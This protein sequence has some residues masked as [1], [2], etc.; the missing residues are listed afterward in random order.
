MES[1]GLGW[2]EVLA[3]LTT[4]PAAR[5]GE[6]SRRGRIARGMEA[7]LVVLA[8]DPVTDVRAF[9]D[10]RYTLRA[11]KVIY[12]AAAGRPSDGV[13][14]GHLAAL[15]LDLDEGPPPWLDTGGE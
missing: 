12:S 6:A 11:G 7:D 9:A 13:A 2:R 5:F 3:S 4:H 1:A 14:P 15:R 10:V 8:R